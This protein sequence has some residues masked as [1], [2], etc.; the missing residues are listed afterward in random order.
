MK[1][2]SHLC[3]TFQQPNVYSEEQQSI[4]KHERK[5][6]GPQ[7]S[8]KMICALTIEERDKMFEIAEADEGEKGL[9]E[10]DFS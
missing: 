2:Q 1:Q 5:K 4:L 3:S 7:E 10:K 9:F 8:N 6:P